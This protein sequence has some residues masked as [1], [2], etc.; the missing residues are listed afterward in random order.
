MAKKN[1]ASQADGRPT[2]QIAVRCL[3]GIA[4]G[5]SAYLAAT[6][7]SASGVAGC[8]PE[9]GCSQVLQSRWAYWAGIPVSLPAMG[10]YALMLFMTFRSGH[11]AAARS[12]E[13]APIV[14]AAGALMILGAALW[15]LALQVG[16]IGKFCAYCLTAHAA[17]SVAA[18]LILRAAPG[19]GSDG[20]RA[21]RGA[22]ARATAVPFPRTAFI[23]LAGIAVLIG[24]QLVSPFRTFVVG[25]LEEA[26]SP[27]GP[28]ASNSAANQP[29]TDVPQTAAETNAAN[30]PTTA[31]A[32]TVPSV[33][34]AS[35]SGRRYGLFSG[36]I[37]LNLDEAPLHG[38][39]TAPVVI[40]SLRDY[41]CHY[42]RIMHGRLAEVRRAL[43]D[44][45]AIVGLPMPMNT[46]CNFAVRRTPD[47]HEN[48]CDYARLALGVWRADRAKLEGF[49][50]WMFAP[51]QPPPPAEARAFAEKLVGV[52]ALQRALA[53]AWIEQQLH[54][55]ISIYATNALYFK[56]TRMPQ[57]I[58]GQRIIVG[59]VNSANDIYS[60]LKAQPGLLPPGFTLPTAE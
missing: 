37:Q 6:S 39:P 38:P 35:P 41:A 49:E 3:L 29:S 40:I 18:V 15:F 60:M 42:C 50:D 44:Q 21:K 58:V 56:Q 22:R 27:T 47:G 43:G 34:E 46:A 57:T 28:A 13:P 24:G 19:H 54:Q 5:I 12:R 4:L 55:D 31:A 20:E 48:A 25:S 26:T 16:V 9:S 59:H 53:D 36:K 14:L 23:A 52:E 30:P 10:L 1:R 45:V 51:E 8:G 7:L 17:G 2:R 11:N 33:N 32:P